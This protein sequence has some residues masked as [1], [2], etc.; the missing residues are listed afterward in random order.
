[1]TDS[2][3]PGVL[4]RIPLH[5]EAVID[6]FRS[7]ADE[8]GTAYKDL[9]TLPKDT[10]IDKRMRELQGLANVL[11]RESQKFEKLQDQLGGI[12][13][14]DILDT[15]AARA[16]IEDRMARIRRTSDP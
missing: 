16:E 10:E 9:K 15:D 12:V 1:M 14:Q 13:G 3:D 2:N 6:L 5:I 8:V 7:L 4:G 11:V